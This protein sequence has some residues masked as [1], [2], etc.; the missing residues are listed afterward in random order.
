MRSNTA[1]AIFA[2]RGGRQ[3]NW[4]L[5]R[6]GPA[7]LDRLMALLRPDELAAFDRQAGAMQA[8]QVHAVLL[9]DAGYPRALAESPDAPAALFHVGPIELLGGPALAVCGAHESGGAG[10]GQL[11]AAKTAARIAV[12]SGLAVV[13]GDQGGVGGAAVLAALGRGGTAGVVLAEVIGQGRRGDLRG[14]AALSSDRLVMVSQVPPGLPWSIDT[15]MARNATLAGLCTA[16]VAVAAASTG[17]TVDAGQRALAAGK[18]VLAVGDT[19]GSRLL[20]D[21]GATP[22]RDHVEL[23]WWLDR[24][25]ADHRDFADVLPGPA[26]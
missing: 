12:D 6:H 9:G 3:V 15:A 24:L 22:A 20:V 8:W 10:D 23:A 26:G 13:S 21:H 1:R 11:T 25:R 7:E 14:G 19:A 2:A 5:R 4:L 16:L 18:P 17:T